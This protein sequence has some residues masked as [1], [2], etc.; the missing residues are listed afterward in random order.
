MGIEVNDKFFKVVGYYDKEFGYTSNML[1]FV[2]HMY[3]VDNDTFPIPKDE[4]KK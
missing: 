1:R 4:G 2:R 3:K